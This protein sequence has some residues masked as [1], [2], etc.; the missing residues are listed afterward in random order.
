MMTRH[1][2][3]TAAGVS[4]EALVN[5][6]GCITITE[7]IISRSG[8]ASSTSNSTREE[9]NP[10]AEK[11]ILLTDIAFSETIDEGE[12]LHLTVSAFGSFPLSY[13]W[14]KNNVNIQ[15]ATSS[16]Y[17]KANLVSGDAGSYKCLVSN[18]Y[19]SVASHTYVLT[20]HSL[21]VAPTIDVQPE[22]VT[23]EAGQEF[24][25]SVTA[26]GT[27]TLLYQWQYSSDNDVFVDITDAT[28]SSY[29]DIGV[30]G[31]EGNSGFYRC[32]VSNDIGSI[33]SSSAELHVNNP[34]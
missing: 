18:S 20:V 19:G 16:I 14:K 26:S 33:N 1:S 32:Y 28:N 27:P 10:V 3:T 24:T 15:G 12:T 9:T 29:V 23:V 21:G 34:N 6:P 30:A 31:G 7:S 8:V 22:S 4:Q 17:S 25:F 2:L 11:P 13:Q 5:A